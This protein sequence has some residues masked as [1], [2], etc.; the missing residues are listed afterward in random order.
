MD[1][2][3][4]GNGKPIDYFQDNWASMGITTIESEGG[5]PTSGHLNNS[6]GAKQFELDLFLFFILIDP[7]IVLYIFVAVLLRRY[8]ISYYY[9]DAFLIWPVSF[10]AERL[11]S[12]GSTIEEEKR[13]V[14]RPGSH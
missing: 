9:T 3:R 7:L 2:S 1:I 5:K 10:G 11:I 14:G 12:L 4:T 13:R 8:N 6:I